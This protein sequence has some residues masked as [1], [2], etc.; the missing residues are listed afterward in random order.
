MTRK[1]KTKFC[2]A[3][4]NLLREGLKKAILA[5]LASMVKYVWTMI[6]ASILLFLST[7]LLGLAGVLGI[8]ITVPAYIVAVTIVTI[9]LGVLAFQYL[10]KRLKSRR[11]KKIYKGLL[12]ELGKDNDMP[13]PLCPKCEGEMMVSFDKI[14]NAAALLSGKKREYIFTCSKCG[15][16]V[17]QNTPPSDMAKLVQ[18]LFEGANSGG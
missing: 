9:I 11:R 12:W 4:D 17:K 7:L 2:K 1:S 10:L 8:P 13:D 3:V 5:L 18:K 6:G 15:N 16:Q 14:K